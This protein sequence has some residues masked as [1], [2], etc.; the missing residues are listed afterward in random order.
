MRNSMRIIP[1]AKPVKIRIKSGG[2]EHSSLESLK[3]NF[4]VE[5]IFPLLDGRLDRWLRQQ[6]NDLIADAVKAFEEIGIETD[7]SLFRFINCFFNEEL[8]NLEVKTPI[9]LAEYWSNIPYYKKDSELLYKYL[10]RRNSTAAKYLYNNNLVRDVNWFDIFSNFES[11]EDGEILYIL[12]RILLNENDDKGLWYIKRAVK[13]KYDEAKEFLNHKDDS[14]CSEKGPGMRFDGI[15]IE[16]TKF[17]IDKIWNHA[18]NNYIFLNKTPKEEKILRF[19]SDCRKLIDKLPYST[20]NDMLISAKT[21]LNTKSIATD[22]ILYKEKMFVLGLIYYAKR[23]MNDAKKC[24]ERASS[25]PP[26]KGFLNNNDRDMPIKITWRF[27]EQVHY[28]IYHLFDYE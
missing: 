7:E 8:Q 25:Y 14:F 18:I 1:K 22:D 10:L 15:D 2:E 16:K 4:S 19:V 12:G 13:L 23:D 24:F 9:Q 17:N 6:G 21:Y 11:E 20:W 26:A 5:D 27:S 28:V 3:Q